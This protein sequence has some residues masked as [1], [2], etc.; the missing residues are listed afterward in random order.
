ML[1]TFQGTEVI[2]P[3]GYPLTRNAVLW[4]SVEGNPFGNWATASKEDEQ[5]G[6]SISTWLSSVHLIQHDCT[7]LPS[8]P[9][10][11]PCLAVLALRSNPSFWPTIFVAKRSKCNGNNSLKRGKIVAKFGRGYKMGYSFYF[12]HLNRIQNRASEQELF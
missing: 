4:R 10:T 2:Y 9:S 1:P 12:I 7:L 3:C 5:D 11:C 8:I 6:E